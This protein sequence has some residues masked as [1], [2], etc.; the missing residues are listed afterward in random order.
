MTFSFPNLEP[1]CCSMSSSNCCFLSCIQISQEAHQVVWYSHLF[2]NFVQFVVIYTV[3]AFGI[4]N[5]A[6]SG[7]ESC[8]VVSDSLRPHGLYNPWNSPG[9]N[10]GVGGLS[11]LQGIIPTQGLNPSL[12]HCRQILYQLSHKG[13]RSI[14]AWVTYPFSS[15][16]SWPRNWTGASCI[17]GGFFTSWATKLIP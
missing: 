5:K 8:L 16:S 9:Q 2:K 3:K 15:G 17:A 6:E 13:S 14:L 1:V 10:T 12:P 4:V 7:S 11:L